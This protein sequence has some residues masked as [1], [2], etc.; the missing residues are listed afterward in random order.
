VLGGPLGDSGNVL[1]IIDAA[2]ANE[3]NA[4]LE[5]DPWTQSGILE[6]KNIQ[7]WTILLQANE[8]V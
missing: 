6:V 1:L 4:K 7:P 8:K 3:I 2:D 5:R